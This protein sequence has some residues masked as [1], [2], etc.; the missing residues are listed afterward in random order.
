MSLKSFKTPLRYPGGKSR[1]CKKMEPFIPDL[2]D[3]DVYYEPFLGG[4]SVAL[5]IT[6]KYPKLKIY[7]NDL[8]EPLYNFWVQLQTN[9][10]YVHSQ[11]Q[12]LKSTHPDRNSARELFEDAK[13]KL[14]DSDV[15][16]EE[17]AVYF[18]IINKCS[19]SGLTESSSFSE[20]A[21]DA[22]F[23]MRGIDK[24][25]VYTKL[26][27]NWRITNY[28][29]GNFINEILWF[30]NRK[31]FIYLD[32]PYDIKDNLYGKKGSMHKKFDH[33]KFAKDCEIYNSD[34]L[35]SYNSEQLVKNRFKDWNCAEFDLTYTMRSVGEYM[36]NQKTRKELLLFNYNTGVF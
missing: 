28:N 15:T 36:R 5:H 1:A 31:Y 19:F 24:L 30:R 25:P 26:I 32:P 2:R 9:G 8:Y 27:R 35:I 16:D 11:L 12:E 14:Y 10:D 18:Y 7:V 29:Y 21:S 4:G 34:M 6:K 22:N 20:Q 13:E 3:Y 23:S 33:D 17:R